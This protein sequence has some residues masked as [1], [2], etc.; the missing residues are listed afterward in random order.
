VLFCGLLFVDCEK[1]SSKFRNIIGNTIAEIK[2]ADANFLIKNG[3]E[4]IAVDGN[5]IKTDTASYSYMKYFSVEDNKVF[6]YTD[7]DSVWYKVPSGHTLNET[8]GSPATLFQ[9]QLSNTV[10]SVLQYALKDTDK[11][12]SIGFK[13]YTYEMSVAAAAVVGQ[14]STVKFTFT[15]D[16]TKITKLKR[17]KTT[18]TITYG[19]QNVTL[20]NAVEPTILETPKNL[21]ITDGFLLWDSVPEAADY[22]VTVYQTGNFYNYF[23][24]HRVSSAGLNLLEIFQTSP[25]LY[26]Q[27]VIKIFVRAVRSPIFAHYNSE[28]AQT[29]YTYTA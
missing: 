29:E 26:T 25:D 11:V 9:T 19:N 18:Y 28:S 22:E 1:S 8:E 10:L 12:K 24:T 5:K 15:T 21:S 7:I 20:P 13:K 6:F 16:G 3:T 2:K 27:G 4:E 23:T 17:E 14:K